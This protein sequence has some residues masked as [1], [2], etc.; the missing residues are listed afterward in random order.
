MEIRYN[1]EN[2]IEYCIEKDL[3]KNIEILESLFSEILCGR[4]SA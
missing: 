4:H 2:E 1:E 3:A